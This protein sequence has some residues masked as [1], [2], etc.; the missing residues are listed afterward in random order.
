VNIAT[1]GPT[2]SIQRPAK[3]ADR[4]RNTIARLKIQPR[5]VSLQSCGVDCVMPITLVSGPLN[6]LNAYAWPMQRWTASAAGGTSQR[7]KPGRATIR[8]FEKKPGRALIRFL[9]G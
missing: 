5:V 2:R 9:P 6:T 4:P 3:A 1:R 7:L 8:C